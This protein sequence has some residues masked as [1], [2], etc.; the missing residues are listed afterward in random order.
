MENICLLFALPKPCELSSSPLKSQTLPLLLSTGWHR[1]LSCLTA[2][3]LLLSLWGSFIYITK[4]IYLLLICLN[5]NLII[6]PP[7]ELRW[8]ER[9]SLPPVHS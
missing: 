3:E 6:R 1:S 4:F 5:G 2:G 7:K 9:K 8:E